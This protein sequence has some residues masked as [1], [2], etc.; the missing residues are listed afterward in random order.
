MIYWRTAIRDVFIIR[1][2]SYLFIVIMAPAIQD[3]RLAGEVFGLLN[4]L[5]LVICFTIS[6]CLTREVDP[7]VK[8]TELEK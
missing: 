3:K 6:G 5:L 1:A 7:I 8:T 4:I 2:L